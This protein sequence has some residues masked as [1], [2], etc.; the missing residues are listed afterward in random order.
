MAIGRHAGKHT[1]THTH[2]HTPAAKCGQ[3]L[4]GVQR[5]PVRSHGVPNGQGKHW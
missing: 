4:K 5:P 2:T 1:H 3:V